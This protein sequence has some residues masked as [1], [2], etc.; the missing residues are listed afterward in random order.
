MSVEWILNIQIS[1]VSKTVFLTRQR[2][3]VRVTKYFS[4]KIAQRAARS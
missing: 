2:K 1:R 4:A 3:I